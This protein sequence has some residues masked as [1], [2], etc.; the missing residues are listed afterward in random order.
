MESLINKF[1][2]AMASLDLPSEDVGKYKQD[3]SNLIILAYCTKVFGTYSEG[4]IE[5]IQEGRGENIEMLVELFKTKHE[6]LKADHPEI[7]IEAIG[8]PIVDD[9]LKT[10]FNL[11]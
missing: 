5:T 6:E 8:N 4:E 3:L 7:S 11:S 9:Y 1:T 10:V 2:N